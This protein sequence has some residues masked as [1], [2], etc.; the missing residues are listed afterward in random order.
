[1]KKL[2][3]LIVSAIAM[4]SIASAV[5]VT[6]DVAY[7]TK[8]LDKGNVIFENTA[9]AG[10]EIE[11]AGFVVGV[12][13][14]NPTEA[15]TGVVVLGKTLV[16]QTKSSGLFKRVDTYA[17]YK[18]TAPLADL[19]LGAAYKSY[20]KSVQSGGNASN[21]ELFARLNG[22][23]KGTLLTWDAATKVDSKNHTNNVEA[24]LRLP[25][26][27]KWVK[28]APAVGL[29]F[30]DPGAVTIAA[31]KDSK[32]YA[33]VGVGVGYYA[34]NA[35]VAAEY[36]QRRDTFTAPGGV[37]DGVSFGVHYKL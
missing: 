34:K 37:V 9:V 36:Y 2:L 27:F 1:M 16:N 14:F 23:V 18:F 32:R 30:N 5:T 10:A 25:F 8:V 6:T 12:N 17:G 15:K 21:T 20:S 22:N 13:T 19:T 26:G 3:S 28:I 24:N 31:F 11:A 29:G 35:V 4:V 33:L 7:K